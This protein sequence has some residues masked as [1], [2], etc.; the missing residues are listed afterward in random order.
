M[1]SFDFEERNSRLARLSFDGSS[2][3]FPL[4]T[5]HHF[6]PMFTPKKENAKKDFLHADDVKLL[7]FLADGFLLLTKHQIHELFPHWSDKEL[8]GRLA[9]LVKQEYLSERKV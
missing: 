4:G 9:W 2:G 8:E 1:V 5:R 3:A 7:C 6:I